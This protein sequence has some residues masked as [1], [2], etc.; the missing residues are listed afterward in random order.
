MSMGGGGGSDSTSSGEN[1]ANST[2]SNWNSTGS[3]TRG[4]NVSQSQ[5]SQE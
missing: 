4:L 5:T 2:G 3:D 1:F